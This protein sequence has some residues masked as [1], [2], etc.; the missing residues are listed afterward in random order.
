[1]EEVLSR[2][3][4]A[5]VIEPTKDEYVRWAIANNKR[6][7]PD[8]HFQIFMPERDEYDG[9]SLP[10]L[11]LNAFEPACCGNNFADYSSRCERLS[12]VL[13]AKPSDFRYPVG[14]MGGSDLPF[15]GGAHWQTFLRRRDLPA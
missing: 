9:V 12:A 1:L 15:F 4:P 5:L 7:S 11:R 6:T 10:Q 2:G 14:H 8:K 13:S 3:I